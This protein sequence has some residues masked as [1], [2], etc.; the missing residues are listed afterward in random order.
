KSLHSS[1]GVPVDEAFWYTSGAEQLSTSW[2]ALTCWVTDSSTDGVPMLTVTCAGVPQLT[3][4][5]G[6]AVPVPFCWSH[7]VKLKCPVAGPTPDLVRVTTPVIELML[8]LR[9]TRSDGVVICQW[10]AGV[11]SVSGA[12]N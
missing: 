8:A 10:I 5:G 4:G 7:A 12:L 11:P 1:D 3:P 9:R 6:V 2:A